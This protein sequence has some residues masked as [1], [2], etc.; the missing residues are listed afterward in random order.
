MRWRP[1]ETPT[2][3]HMTGYRHEFA[4]AQSERTSQD[5]TNSKAA[6]TV[7]LGRQNKEKIVLLH[8]HPREGAASGW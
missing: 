4:G 1:P 7:M 2:K 5:K 3:I 8:L 6:A